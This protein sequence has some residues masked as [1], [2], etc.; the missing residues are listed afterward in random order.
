[1]AI[2]PSPYDNYSSRDQDSIESRIFDLISS[3]FPKWTNRQRHNFGNILVGGFSFVG[4]LLGFYLDKLARETRWMTAKMRKNV[5]ALAK[6]IDY[7][8]PGAGAATGD[9]RVILKN[10]S[11]LSGTVNIPAGTI[12]RTVEVTDPVKGELQADLNIVVATGEMTGSWEHSLT[13]SPQVV[14]SSGLPDFSMYL[15]FGPYLEDSASVS[16]PT[17]SPWEEVDN[18]LQSRPTDLHY[19]VGV[20]HLDRATITFGDGNQGAIP[21][22]NV[23]VNYK[24]GGGIA[25]NLE[26]GA[27]TVIEGNFVDS[28]GNKAYV[29][30]YNDADTSGGVPREEVSASKVNGPASLRVQTRTVS[31]EDYEINAKRVVGVGRALFLTSNE[32]T[33]IAENRGRLYIIPSDGGT[34]ST[35][36]KNAVYTMC[37]E[38]YPNTTTFQFEVLD[39][40]YKT[41]DTEAWIYLAEGADASTV[42]TAIQEALED[43]YEPMMADGTENPNVDFGWY[44]KDADGNPAGEIAWSDIF[45]VVRDVSG[46]RKVEPTK[47]LLNGLQNDVAIG[48]WQFPAN[49]SLTL[50]NG[51]TG[52]AM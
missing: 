38:T 42:K 19:V 23:T 12:I 43:Y 7:K 8:L 52:T 10:A 3:V 5:I 18:F 29:E 39:P 9:V 51:D 33:G 31:R 21:V 37:T 16:T 35:A 47:F 36:L 44:Y 46:V 1:M 20:D 28:S 24:T 40:V 49:G 32:Q 11:A 41:I 50:I 48:N 6:L 27:L 2:F 30:A 17:Q 15:P 34:P 26:P 22:G 45:N 25:G 14:A 13:Q 4:D